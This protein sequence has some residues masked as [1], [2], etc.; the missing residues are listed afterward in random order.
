MLLFK[1]FA[2]LRGDDG[3]RLRDEPGHCGGDL[4]E[5]WAV[6]GGPDSGE[7]DP[8]PGRDPRHPRVRRQEPLRRLPVLLPGEPGGGHTFGGI[9]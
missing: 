2:G 6:P 8:G 9:R 5:G 1:L 3:N 4:S 7:Q